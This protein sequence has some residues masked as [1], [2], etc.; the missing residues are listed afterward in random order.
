MGFI[1]WLLTGLAASRPRAR[2]AAAR[3]NVRTLSGIGPSVE[4]LEER[5]LF[6]AAHGA[7][8]ALTNAASGNAVAVFDRAAD[9]TL[10][11]AGMVST[12][13]LG[14]GDGPDTEGLQ[15]QGALA[16]AKD[17]NYLYAVNGGSGDISVFAVKSK[18]LT[19]VERV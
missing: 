18:G 9:G 5:R 10:K 1:R 7:V 17:N 2:A 14:I 8:Y 11:A 12:G 3:S 6:S 13:G 19:L 15:S 4:R 16:L